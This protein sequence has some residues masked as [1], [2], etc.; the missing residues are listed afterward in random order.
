M[1]VVGI[2]DVPEVVV[3]VQVILVAAPLVGVGDSWRFL[4]T[5]RSVGSGVLLSGHTWS[6]SWS[7]TSV[8]NSN[9]DLSSLFSLPQSRM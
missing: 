2:R 1:L 8:E 4:L 7:Y 3:A 5:S 9:P 6:R